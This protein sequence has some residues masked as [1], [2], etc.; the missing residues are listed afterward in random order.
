MVKRFLLNCSRVISVIISSV[1]QYR[2][3]STSPW[4]WLEEIRH[5]SLARQRHLLLQH[6]LIASK[7]SYISLSSWC[8]PL[9]V[10]IIVLRHLGVSSIS[11]VASVSFKAAM[12]VSLGWHS[13]SLFLSRAFYF[14]ISKI[15]S[16]VT[17]WLWQSS[18]LKTPS[19]SYLQV[20]ELGLMF[21]VW[22]QM[23]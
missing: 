2:W 22:E 11:P 9:L 5:W 16:S 3:R 23:T 13:G 17:F 12:V 1:Q 19:V 6:L 14:R 4:G 21:W 10:R 18:N 15:W 8:C 20:N 7:H